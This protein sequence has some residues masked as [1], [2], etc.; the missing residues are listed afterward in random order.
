MMW[1]RSKLLIFFIYIIY[2]YVYSFMYVHMYAELS[3]V[4]KLILE[5]V[6]H[7]CRQIA[8]KESINAIYV[9]ILISGLNSISMVCKTSIPSVLV[10]NL[11]WR[12]IGITCHD[13]CSLAPLFQILRSDFLPEMIKVINSPLNKSD[14][15]SI[16]D[17][18]A[19]SIFWDALLELWRFVSGFQ[20]NFP[21]Y[22]VGG[23]NLRKLK[24]LLQLCRRLER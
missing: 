20:L 24:N 14:S 2:M 7:D 21:T 10:K 22:N 15:L 1:F 13:I 9:H 19:K 6:F 11:I 4:G 12:T 5:G 17:Q 18:A 16:R 8:S 23:R 3:W